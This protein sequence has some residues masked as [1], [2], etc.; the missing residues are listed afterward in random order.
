MS[1]DRITM[2]ESEQHA[3]E[4]FTVD[5]LAQRVAL[6][7]STIR[8]YQH[9]G[10]IPP[11]RRE[12][13]GAFYG[14]GH[15]ARI[16]LIGRLQERGFSLAAI[17]DLVR[18]WEQGR[19]LDELLGLEGR[20]AG[21]ARPESIVVTPAELAARFASAVVTPGALARTAEMALIEFTDDGRIRVLSPE[22]L[23]VGSALVDLGF[24][25]DD[26]LDEAAALQTV[27]DGIAER[28]AT[29]FERTIW[30][31]FVER[32]MPADDLP[33]VTDVLDRLLPL[34]DRVVRTTLTRSL[35]ATADRLLAREAAAS[36]RDAGR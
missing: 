10:L 5:E 12:G 6:P 26:V 16:E 31:P 14:A 4:R 22:F 13:R 28:F 35:V 25:L 34:A 2:S 30:R 29:M 15:V 36:A 32:G 8:L 24:S 21:L 1:Y 33:R 18:G 3:A 19:S 20:I 9:R 17:G 23:E 27:T 11:P 7:S